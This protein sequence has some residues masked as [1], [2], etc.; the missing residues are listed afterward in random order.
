MNTTHSTF[1]ATNRPYTVIGGEKL[2]DKKSTPP[3][4][5]V[6]LINRS[7]KFRREEL[8]SELKFLDSSEVIYIEGPEHSYEIE[9]LSRKN[10]EV[11]FLLLQEPISTGEKITI[12]FEESRAALCL[13]M[14]SDMK[15]LHNTVPQKL[16]ARLESDKV[17]CTSPILKNAR[18]ELIPS[19]LAPAFIK[20]RLQILPFNPARDETASIYPFDYSGI[21]SKEK[22]FS[23]GGYDPIITNP[24]WQKMDLGFRSCLWGERI[25]L[26]TSFVLQYTSSIETEDATPDSSYK[27][28]FVKNM[29]VTCKRGRASINP[30]KVFYYMMKGDSGPV[31]SWREFR[32][33]RVWV[34]ANSSRFKK[35]AKSLIR[36]WEAP[37]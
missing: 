22:Y 21:Y 4:L 11:K 9:P 30:L 33:A 29:F 14:W 8:L 10:P 37:E 20:K 13:V 16:M 5:S 7:G 35:D 31:K 6:I 12:G 26:T 25:E 3:A 2:D 28:F 19:L 34:N 23:L 27:F 18:G 36:S 24:Y 32:D 17:F 15:I 1:K